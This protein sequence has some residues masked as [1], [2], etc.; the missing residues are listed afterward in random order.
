MS[1]KASD[2]RFLWDPINNGRP[3]AGPA[4]SDGDAKAKQI[5]DRVR[6]ASVVAAVASVAFAAVF[7]NMFTAVLAGLITHISR[8]AYQVADNIAT[9]PSIADNARRELAHT[10]I[11]KGA[12]FARFLLLF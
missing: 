5:A 1:V 4:P 7:F 9:D 6:V 8:D 3:P 2:N 11:T 10:S 12:F